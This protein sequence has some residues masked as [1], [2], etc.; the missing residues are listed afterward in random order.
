MNFL[1]DYLTLYKK[2][3][4]PDIF[5][6]WGGLCGIS[7]VLGRRLWL[8]KAVFT[9]YPNIYVILV[10]ASGRMRKSTAVDALENNLRKL[11]S[12]PNLTCQK[13]TGPE[14]LIDDIRRRETTD[15]KHF[16]RE[17]CEASIL[18][19]EFKV[20]LNHRTY[21]AGLGAFLIPL[22]D[23]KDYYRYRTKSRGIEEMQNVCVMLFGGSTVRGIKEA[24]PVA[25]IGD[26]LTSRFVFVYADKPMPPEPNPFI[27]PILKEKVLRQLSEMCKLCGQVKLSPSANVFFDEWYVDFCKNSLLF[28]DSSL[29][30][31]ASRRHA[32]L[33]KTAMLMAVSEGSSFEIQTNHL[34]RA[35][36]LL[37]QTESRMPEVM[38]L[39]TSSE[40]GALAE[41]VHTKISLTGSGGITRKKLL[42]QFRFRVNYRELTLL[43]E[44]L[45]QSDLIKA[46]SSGGKIFYVSTKC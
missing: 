4:I 3:E 37:Q 1:K 29:S 22:W 12:P 8:D 18:L 14:A 23:A 26:G 40:E 43:I 38:S 10:A 36:L 5:T 17:T 44:T 2:T 7:S 21:E 28:E 45:I 13:I 24:L 11:T 9:I 25:A 41:L 16:L 19:D 27:C 6:L 35:D 20:F 46:Y 30:G 15:S 34:K 39:I 31:Y 33:L 42:S 32:H